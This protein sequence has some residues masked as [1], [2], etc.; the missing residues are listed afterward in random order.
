MDRPD[1]TAYRLLNLAYRGKDHPAF[2]AFLVFS[3]NLRPDQLGDEAFL[4]RIGY[5]L[6]LKN[7]SADEFIEIF[8]RLCAKHELECDFGLADWFVHRYYTETGKRMRRCQ[9][10]DV[11]S[12]ALDLIHFEKLPAVL[13]ED[14]LDRS[15]R[16]CFVEVGDIEG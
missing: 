3:T 6:H 4:R 10:R 11:I 8:Y 9:P 1:G 13:S 14:L 16:T 15:F 5:K 7:P 2:E 12:H